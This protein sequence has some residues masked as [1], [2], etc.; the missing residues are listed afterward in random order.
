MY[1]S[2]PQLYEHWKV[3]AGLHAISRGVTGSSLCANILTGEVKGLTISYIPKSWAKN[4]FSSFPTAS[5]QFRHNFQ[6]DSCS[7]ALMQPCIFFG[8][9]S[10]QSRTGTFSKGTLCWVALMRTGSI[11]YN[12]QLCATQEVGIVWTSIWSLSNYS[13]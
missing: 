5:L 11:E 10:Y 6:C 13:I 2:Q 1:T 4:W 8:A 3:K 7:V 12:A 9:K